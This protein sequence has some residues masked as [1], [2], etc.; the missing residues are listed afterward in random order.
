MRIRMIAGSAILGGALTMSGMV[1]VGVAPAGAAV[2]QNFK[3][4]PIGTVT[5][6]FNVSESATA[7]I[8]KTTKMITLS[9]ATFTVRNTFGVSATVN[10][11]KFEI[12]DPNNT[13]APYIAN[14][15]KVATS[16]TGWV[17][18]HDTGIFAEHAGSEVFKALATLKNA[19]L[20]AKYTDA[21]PVKTVINFIAGNFTFN[22]T[23][24]VQQAETCTPTA[25]A[26][27]IAHVAE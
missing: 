16:P 26:K 3:C 20:S 5:P 12:T 1:L 27:I 13:S 6:S 2:T 17:A 25:P 9:N 11:I 14:S 8:N 4:T 24:P 23:S 10:S 22:I 19:A 7:S 15:V 18:G 21:G